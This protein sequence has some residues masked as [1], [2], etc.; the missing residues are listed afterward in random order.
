MVDWVVGITKDSG[1]ETVVD[2][3]ENDKDD[4]DNDDTTGVVELE[5]AMTSV[6]DADNVEG[7]KVDDEA[8]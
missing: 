5:V 3:N 1:K 6:T 2:A 7:I 4:V 8:T